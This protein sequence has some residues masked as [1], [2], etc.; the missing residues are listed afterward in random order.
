MTE[1]KVDASFSDI[2]KDGER[3]QSSRSSSDQP[4]TVTLAYNYIDVNYIYMA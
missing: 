2:E 4:R 3:F 1:N